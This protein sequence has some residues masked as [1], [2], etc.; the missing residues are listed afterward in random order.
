[1][2]SIKPT[3][4]LANARDLVDLLSEV[5]PLTPAEIAE[6]I[7]VPRPSIYRLVDGLNAINLTET[8]PDARVALSLRWLHIADEARSAMEEWAGAKAA[9]LDLVDAT[10]QTAFLSVLRDDNAVC[11]DWVPGRGI[12][13]LTFKPGRALPLH[14]GAAGRLLLAYAGDLDDYMKRAPLAKLTPSTLTAAD[15]LRDDIQRTLERGFSVSDE[16]ATVG[17][18]HSA[19]RFSIRRAKCVLACRSGGWPRTC[20]R[21]GTSTSRRWIAPPRRFLLRPTRSRRVQVGVRAL[22]SVNATKGSLGNSNREAS[23]GGT[24]RKTDDLSNI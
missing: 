10:G 23:G 12:G 5:G 21:T 1:M 22:P 11:I 9:L 19:G 15:E 18:A 13:V 4:V 20:E 6:R 17:L 3:R 24:A 8:L 2:K 16:D 7:D 14:A